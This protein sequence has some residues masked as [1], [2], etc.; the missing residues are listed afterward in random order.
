MKTEIRFLKK[1][2]DGKLAIAI[3]IARM[4][5]KWVICR[6]SKRKT[7]EFPGGHREAGE[8]IEE[9]AARELREETGATAFSLERICDF[10][11]LSPSREDENRSEETFG[12]LFYAEITER[13]ENLQYEIEKVILVESFSDDRTYHVITQTLADKFCGEIEKTGKAPVVSDE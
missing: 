5:G 10:S 3:M 7:Y 12:A 8:T 1:A 9:T 2:D 6:H 11:V 4:D 13:T